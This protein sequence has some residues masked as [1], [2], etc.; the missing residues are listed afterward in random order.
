[1]EGEKKEHQKVLGSP[2]SPGILLKWNHN[3]SSCVGHWAFFLVVEELLHLKRKATAAAMYTSTQT[4]L[5]TITQMFSAKIFCPAFKLETEKSALC[6]F[7]LRGNKETHICQDRVSKRLLE[8]IWTICNYTA[9][10]VWCYLVS[11]MTIWWPFFN[12]SQW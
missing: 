10:T 2:P 5:E 7:D 12:S 4:N 9:I 6:N 11:H 8:A 3:R 1:M